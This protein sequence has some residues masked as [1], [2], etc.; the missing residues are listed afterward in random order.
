M[1]VLKAEHLP[2]SYGEIINKLNRNI[3]IK[4]NPTVRFQ[5][6]PHIYLPI[7]SFK[8]PTGMGFQL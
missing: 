8:M 1:N 4:E 6:K 7:A 2:D 5:A 3:F